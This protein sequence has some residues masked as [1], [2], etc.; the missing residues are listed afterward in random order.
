MLNKN[1]RIFIICIIT[2]LLYAIIVYTFINIKYHVK[3]YENF[4][5]FKIKFKKIFFIRIFW[6]N[7]IYWNNLLK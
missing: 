4:Y 5:I 1:K 2:L 3:I 7:I 6:N